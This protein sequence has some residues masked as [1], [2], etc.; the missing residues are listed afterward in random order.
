MNEIRYA[1]RMTTSKGQFWWTGIMTDMDDAGHGKFLTFGWSGNSR[2]AYAYANQR[3]AAMKARSL[4]DS[5]HRMFEF[6]IEVDPVQWSVVW[7]WQISEV[8][9]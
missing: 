6:E 3:N 5:L 7:G 9:A 8:A 1:I 4:A 2:R